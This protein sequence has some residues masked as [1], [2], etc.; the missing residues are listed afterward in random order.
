M[1]QSLDLRC[2]RPPKNALSGIIYWSCIVLRMTATVSHESFASQ[3]PLGVLEFSNGGTTAVIKPSH[4]L[5]CQPKMVR[6]LCFKLKP[7]GDTIVRQAGRHHRTR[8]NQMKVEAE[9]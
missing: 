5:S 2:C 4:Q 7:P 3:S 9:S 6:M 8:R 1:A